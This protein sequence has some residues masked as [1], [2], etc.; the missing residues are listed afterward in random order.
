MCFGLSLPWQCRQAPWWHCHSIM[1]WWWSK[2]KA[3]VGFFQSDWLRFD[4]SLHLPLSFS[5]QA[6][7]T[8]ADQNGYLTTPFSGLPSNYCSSDLSCPVLSC[9]CVTQLTAALPSPH[10]DQSEFCLPITICFVRRSPRWRN[11]HSTGRWSSDRRW[12]DQLMFV[13]MMLSP[14]NCLLLVAASQPITSV[15][16]SDIF[17]PVSAGQKMRLIDAHINDRPTSEPNWREQQNLNF[18]F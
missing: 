8:A 11:G 16:V 5:P 14:L 6:L 17:A 3:K 15:A 2:S 12:L 10:T 9:P 13:H 1:V 18:R 4:C 7:V